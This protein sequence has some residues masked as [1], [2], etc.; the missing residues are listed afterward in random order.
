MASSAARCS[1]KSSRDSVQ[2][3]VS[4]PAAST[5]RRLWW[6]GRR[7]N[8]VAMPASSISSSSASSRSGTGSVVV[9]RLVPER[10]PQGRPAHSEQVDLEG[11]VDAVEPAGVGG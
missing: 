3:G 4:I 2:V 6:A 10:L 9:R 5:A 1:W 11:W 8:P 7:A